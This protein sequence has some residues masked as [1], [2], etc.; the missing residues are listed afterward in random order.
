[1]SLGK[2]KPGPS[3]ERTR[4]VANLFAILTDGNYLLA[5]CPDNCN[6]PTSNQMD[7]N[8][9][10]LVG[11]FFFFFPPVLLNQYRRFKTR[12]LQCEKVTVF[13]LELEIRQY[14]EGSHKQHKGEKQDF[15]KDKQFLQKQERKIHLPLTTIKTLA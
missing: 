8:V 3:R 6:I 5:R 11:G 13:N 9:S 12:S 2:Q 14:R 15:K 1:M 4:A 10:L 7:P